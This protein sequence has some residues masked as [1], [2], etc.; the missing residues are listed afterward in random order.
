MQREWRSNPPVHHL[1]AAY[2]QYKPPRDEAT[3]RV[4]PASGDPDIE[5]LLM[6]TGPVPIRR[7]EPIDTSAF[8][9]AMAAKA[10]RETAATN[11]EK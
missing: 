8:D 11:E 10:A 6:H 1:V 7:Y 4:G 3:V 9:A 2:M 5:E